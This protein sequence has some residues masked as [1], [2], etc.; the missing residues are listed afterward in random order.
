MV[1][2]SLL[3]A[4]VVALVAADALPPPLLVGTPEIAGGNEAAI[5]QHLYV[6]GLRNTNTSISL[7]GGILIAPKYVLTAAH[8]VGGVWARFAAIGTHYLN[9]SSD[10]ELIRVKRP[11]F[12]PQYNA[13]TFDNDFGI[14]ELERPS[15]MP[16]VSISFDDTPV[17]SEATV[18][19]W[20]A[21]AH[22]TAY[23][24]VLKEVS[25][26]LWDNAVCD[27]AIQKSSNA[28]MP[29][30]TDSMLCAGGV[31]GEDACAGDSGGP[32]TVQ[33]NGKD[34]VIGVVSWGF[35]CAIQNSPGVYARLSKAKEF[36][37]P[38]LA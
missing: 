16:P 14:L 38:F 7:C 6:T 31:A 29:H 22:G 18:R 24:Q 5:G 35:K 11:F 25:V 10:G 8:C 32:L 30:V 4:L 12:H 34:V 9:G 1:Y 23:S 37:Q 13:W 19:G 33:Q 20:G 3:T 26:K 21:V 2:S 17:G 36:L 15:N 28:T 27:A